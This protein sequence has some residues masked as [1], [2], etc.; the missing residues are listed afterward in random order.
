MRGVTMS[1]W[2]MIWSLL[3]MILTIPL[4]AG[5]VSA[6]VFTI[7]MLWLWVASFVSAVSHIRRAVVGVRNG[8]YGSPSGAGSKGPP[9]SP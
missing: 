3:S 7:G 5:H 4:G 6:I 2:M 9:P 1:L 8:S